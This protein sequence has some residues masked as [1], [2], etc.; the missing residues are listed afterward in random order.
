MSSAQFF[1]AICDI[2]KSLIGV[3]RPV[4]N[5]RT[6]SFLNSSFETEYS[7]IRSSLHFA[8][9]PNRW[10]FLGTICHSIQHICH[11]INCIIFSGIILYGD[12]RSADFGRKSLCV[13]VRILP[14]FGCILTERT[15]GTVQKVVAFIQW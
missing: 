12:P 1:A 6:I 4:Q 9:L 5:P 10:K 7:S 11:L 3:G 8:I 14:R 2:L 13:L 15:A